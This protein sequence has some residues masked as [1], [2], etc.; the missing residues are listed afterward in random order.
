MKDYSS[1]VQNLETSFSRNSEYIS[2]SPNLPMRKNNDSGFETGLNGQIEEVRKE[3]A[4]TTVDSNKTL[5]T[6]KI[7]LN[8]KNLLS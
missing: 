2:S 7:L 5:L 1:K 8:L 3:L 4:K 6:L